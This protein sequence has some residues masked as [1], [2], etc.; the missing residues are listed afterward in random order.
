M[1]AFELLKVNESLL[2]AMDGH[3][4]AINDVRYIDMMSEFMTMTKEGHKK[5][6]IIQYLA[7]KYDLAERT[8]YRVIERMMQEIELN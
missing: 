1:K 3:S 8:L 7:D 4:L 5:T 2:R 6:Y